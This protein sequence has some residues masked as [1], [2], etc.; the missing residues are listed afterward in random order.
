MHF[1]ITS[2]A[3]E[4]FKSTEMNMKDLTRRFKND[5]NYVINKHYSKTDHN[6]KFLQDGD[7]SRVK[8]SYYVSDGNEETPSFDSCA[9]NYLKSETYTDLNQCI[10]IEGACT[11]NNCNYDTSVYYAW[12]G[13]STDPY[14]GDVLSSSWGNY[15]EGPDNPNCSGEPVSTQDAFYP[16]GECYVNAFL[17]SDSVSGCYGDYSG[18]PTKYCYFSYLDVPE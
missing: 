1:R 2:S 5:G 8:V 3:M 9:S 10:T 15:F 13:N 18:C 7:P 14:G 4:V 17:C 16:W 12:V 6:R 11:P